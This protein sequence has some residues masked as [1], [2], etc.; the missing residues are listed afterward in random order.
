[1]TVSVRDDG[2]LQ[3]QGSCEIEDAET[4]LQILS[5]DAKVTVD[6]RL[7][8]YAHTAVI[9]VLMALQ[10]TLIGPPASDFLTAYLGDFL[11]GPPRDPGT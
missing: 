6:W 5:V 7:C 4:L 2:T 8:N 1:M 9:Q 11:P 10:P 3:L